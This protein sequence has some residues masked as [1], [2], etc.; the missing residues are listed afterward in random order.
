[1]SEE[2][3]IIGRENRIA[4]I[5]INRPHVM[6]A[7]TIEVITALLDAFE[8]V[9]AEKNLRVVIFEGAGG[10]FSTGADMSMLQKDIDSSQW[11]VWMKHPIGKLILTIRKIP[12]PVIC[13]VRGNVVGYGLGL[14]LAGDFVVA[15]NDA[16]FREV[17]VNLGVTLDGGA[18]YF[19]PRLVGMAKARE[20][21]LLGDVIDGKEAVSMGL[22]YKAVPDEELDNFVRSLADIL[23]HKSLLAM[24]DI[25]ES[26]ER[27]F[28]MSLE[29]ALEWEASHQAILLTGEELQSSVRKFMKYRKGI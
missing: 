29:E 7:V 9:G 21:A 27:S 13:K 20:I 12:Q 2:L 23:S 4:T 11:F 5:T 8:T 3:V 16:K 26:L 17:F 18:S 24:S 1:M 15:T 25:K 19:L 6:N 14:A 10:N 22:I 28:D